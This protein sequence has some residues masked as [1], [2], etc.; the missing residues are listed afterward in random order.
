MTW[1]LWIGLYLHDV[2]Q[3]IVTSG[4]MTYSEC[5]MLKDHPNIVGSYPGYTIACVEVPWQN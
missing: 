1:F 5:L 3:P 4:P 2:F